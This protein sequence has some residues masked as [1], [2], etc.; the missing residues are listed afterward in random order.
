M[1]VIVESIFSGT[2]RRF[3]EYLFSIKEIHRKIE[4]WLRTILWNVLIYAR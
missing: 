3:G 2:K 4:I 1:R